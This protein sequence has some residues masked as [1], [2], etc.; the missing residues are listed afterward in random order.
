LK[1]VETALFEKSPEEEFMLESL[2]IVRKVRG[3]LVDIGK[4]IA[5]ISPR[6][7]AEVVRAKRLRPIG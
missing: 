4:R 2:G 1:A 6:V 5:N 7:R 3:R